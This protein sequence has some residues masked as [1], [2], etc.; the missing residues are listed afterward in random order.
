MKRLWS[1]LGSLMIAVPLLIT[2][3]LVLAWGTIY[4]SRFGTAAVQRF[5][6]HSW[7]FQGLLAFLAINLAIAALERRPWQR[8]HQPFLLAHLGIILILLGGITGGRFGIEGQ[9]II[10]EGQAERMLQLPQNVLVVRQPNP[11][12]SRVIPTQFE[13]TAWLHEPHTLFQIP[14]EGRTVQLVV[15]RYY[16]DAVT[17][18]RV[19][20][21]G[22]TENPAL[23]IVLSHDD[24][25]EELWLLVN[26]PERFG[27]RW[28][29]AHVLFLQP[30]TEQQF[31]ALFGLPQPTASSRGVVTIELPDAPA[32]QDIP[33]PQDFSHPVPIEGTPY[34]VMFKDY[35]AD[36][37][38]TEQGPVSRSEEPNNPAVSLLLSG[39][40]GTDAHL[41]FAF[42]PDFAEIH[43]RTHRIHAHVT[44]AAA[45][46]PALPP[47]T[48]G[49]VRHPSGE[50]S[51]VLTDEAGSPYVAACRVGQRYT[52]QGLG[53]QFEIA[54]LYPHAEVTHQFVNRSDEVHTEA[55][56][57]MAQDGQATAE[58]WVELRET[59]A[60]PLSPHPITV[61]YRPAQ[62]ELPFTVKLLD[63]RKI[64]YPGTQMAAGFESDVE[65]TDSQRGLVLM[66]TISMNN[67]LR[68][69]GF[70]LYQSSYI[71]GTTETTVLSVRN[72]PGTPLVYA[73]FVIVILGVVA[74]FATHGHKAQVQS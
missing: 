47:Q 64:D 22:E 14:L 16:P 12:V 17:E 4:E 15:D 31:T 56:H 51:C 35:F 54:A 24:Q 55:L 27:A 61:E 30:D 67:P 36:F 13:T 8:K 57:V 3:A 29:D 74:M 43:G 7:W 50:L 21:G 19:T 60:L 62:R 9:L 48:I 65:L 69:R 42:H 73:G 10:P 20:D 39:P 26:D 25:Q 40:E 68:Y 33:V 70:S 28:G 58:T 18:E 45:I 53:Y 41:L 32:H 5:I 71:P 66:R 38:L 49:V 52:H 6:Y 37:A 1:L 34:V 11:G 72:D 44:Y 63:F 2:I 46:S 59:A 23:N